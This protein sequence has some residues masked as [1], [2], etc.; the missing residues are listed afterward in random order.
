MPAPQEPRQHYP[1]HHWL[2]LLASLFGALFIGV[3]FVKIPLIFPALVAGTCLLLAVLQSFADIALPAFLFC[4]VAVP[5]YLRLPPIGPLPPPPIAISMLVSLVAAAI[6]ATMTG[7]KALPLSRGGRWLLTAFLLWGVVMLLS[8]I[9]ERT[10]SASIN[11][12]IK[13]VVFPL[14]VMAV[15]VKVLRGAASVDTCYKA[16][17]AAAV[18]ISVY[19]VWEYSSGENWLMDTFVPEGLKEWS[20]DEFNALAAAGE[21]YRSFSVFTQPIEF[22]TC[23]GIIYTYALVQLGFAASLK[24]RLAYGFIAVVCLAGIASSFSRMPLA[25]AMLSAMLVSI[26]VPTLRK[27]LAA[28]FALGCFALLAAWPWIGEMIA[29]RLR[30][31]DNL[32]VRVK[33]WEAATAIFWDHPLLGV[34]IGNFPLYHIEAIRANRIGPFEEFGG[35]GIDRISVAESTYYQ[36]SAEGGI[37][38]LA[39]FAAVVIAFFLL[40]IRG[41]RASVRC[42]PAQPVSC[43]RS[44]RHKLPHK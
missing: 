36:M 32:T 12:W 20:A 26:I 18:V 22:A 3:V 17:L 4:L 28:G 29:S 42:P 16:L 11:M 40:V 9:D 37:L 35:A 19:G 39:S 2:A 10:N 31:V 25:A 38:G 6:L 15:L 13:A 8:L 14:V 23:V 41:Y 24:Q 27:W 21:S 44:W 5:V 33:L 34:G 7:Q 30:D 1:A 43:R